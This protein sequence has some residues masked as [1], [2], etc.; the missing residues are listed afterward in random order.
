MWPPITQSLLPSICTQFSF[1]TITRCLARSFPV[2]SN[3]LTHHSLYFFK[4]AC[5]NSLLICAVF[6]YWPQYRIMQNQIHRFRLP[7]NI[8][9]IDK[10]LPYCLFH[11]Y[12]F[13]LC[14]LVCLSVLI[15]LYNSSLIQQYESNLYYYP[16]TEKPQLRFC[17]ISYRNMHFSFSQTIS[18][19]WKFNWNRCV[20]IAICLSISLYKLSVQFEMILALVHSNMIDTLRYR[21]PLFCIS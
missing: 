10:L 19:A 2:A 3:I 6:L 9:I 13:K 12:C 11:Y 21:F 17:Y 18:T 20:C 15:D 14:L 1:W 8:K 7:S 4:S 16:P 5:V